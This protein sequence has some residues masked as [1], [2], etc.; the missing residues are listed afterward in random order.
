MRGDIVTCIRD[1]ECRFVNI[2]TITYSSLIHFKEGESYSLLQAI[3]WMGELELYNVIFE[4]DAKVVVDSFNKPQLDLSF[5]GFTLIFYNIPSIF[6]YHT[7][8][9]KIHL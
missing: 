4:L 6:P 5:F 9:F 3:K 8:N 1:H 2:K 7:I